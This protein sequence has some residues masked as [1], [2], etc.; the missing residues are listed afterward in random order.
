MK[1]EFKEIELEDVMVWVCY[2]NGKEIARA[3]SYEG[4]KTK[5]WSLILKMKDR[6]NGK[7]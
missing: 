2:L 1:V 7:H 4:L 3:W 6:N 5:I